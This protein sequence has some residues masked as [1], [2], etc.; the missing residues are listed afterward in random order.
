[1]WN[2]RYKQL[3]R[4]ATANKWDDLKFYMYINMYQ[5]DSNIY[6]NGGNQM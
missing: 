6:K 1:M 4:P 5:K 2:V 3:T